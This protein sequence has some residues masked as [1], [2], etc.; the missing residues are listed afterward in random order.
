MRTSV[1][2]HSQLSCSQLRNITSLLESVQMLN[3]VAKMA[4][5]ALHKE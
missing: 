4:R 5:T 3:S 2:L 1:N